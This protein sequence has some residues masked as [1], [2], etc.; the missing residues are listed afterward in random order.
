MFYLL[1]SIQ[2]ETLPYN[3]IFPKT[4]YGNYHAF[5]SINNELTLENKINCILQLSLA[6]SELH[7][8]DIIHCNIRTKM[9]FV[10][11]K[12]ENGSLT[13]LLGGFEDAVINVA[14]KQCNPFIVPHLRMIAPEVF[15][16]FM[17]TKATDIYSFG[18]TIWEIF[19][20]RKHFHGE[21][22]K[23]IVLKAFFGDF[24]KFGNFLFLHGRK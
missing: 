1:D 6:L 2:V 21:L 4:A 12:D 17:Y 15:E 23:N 20:N 11:K 7:Q 10:D 14:E 5:I 24:K 8:H 19:S 3:R 16:T 9:I 22:S 13:F 18:I